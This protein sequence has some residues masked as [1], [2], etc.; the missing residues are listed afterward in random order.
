MS[1]IIVRLL[2]YLA[3]RQSLP[4]LL[5]KKCDMNDSGL[6]YLFWLSKSA[7]VRALWNVMLKG[8]LLILNICH[9]LKVPSNVCS[10][11]NA[12]GGATIVCTYNY[13]NADLETSLSSQLRKILLYT[14][15]EVGYPK[16][17]QTQGDN[18][19]PTQTQRQI[20]EPNPN[21][22][23]KTFIVAKHKKP[24]NRG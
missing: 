9:W 10:N 12:V 8:A 6:G 19:N 15:D 23:I 22:D 13:L 16:K 3:S 17:T 20:Q 2:K 18:L 7:L 14:C 5:P 11:W 4:A 1:Y 24:E 21:P